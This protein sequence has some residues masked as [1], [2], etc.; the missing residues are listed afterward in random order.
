MLSTWLLEAIF[1][2][3]GS[4][5]EV[6]TLGTA[7]LDESVV[8]AMNAF[9]RLSRIDLRKNRSVTDALLYRFPPVLEHVTHL[10]LAHTNATDAGVTHILRYFIFIFIY[11]FSLHLIHI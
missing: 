8:S 6:L 2:H 4:R 10:N 7:Q 9:A 3:W 5:M 1:T 11:L